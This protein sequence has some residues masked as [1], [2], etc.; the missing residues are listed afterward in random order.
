MAAVTWLGY[1]RWQ[2]SVPKSD[3][4]LGHPGDDLLSGLVTARDA[5][6]RLSE[7]ELIRLGV[8]LLI[9]GH[10]TTA[11][12]IGNSIT[13]LLDDNRA[14]W[15]Q[16]VAHPDLIPVAVEELLRYIPMAASADFARVAREDIMIGGQ[17]VSAGD[18]VLVQ[19]HAA[20][21]DEAVFA[22]PD[23]S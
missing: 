22:A 19:L 6:D 14:G 11:N 2:P 17:Q 10:E 7:E 12:Q 4:D 21:R 13:V 16:V 5:D 8:T 1:Q 3:A 23:V 9:S 18:A 15:Q 20:N